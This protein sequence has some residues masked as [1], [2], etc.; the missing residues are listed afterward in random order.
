MSTSDTRTQRRVLHALAVESAKLGIAPDI[1]TVARAA[2]VDLALV[3]SVLL[4]AEASGLVHRNKLTAGRELTPEGVLWL[5]PEAFGGLP[6]IAGPVS[7]RPR[8]IVGRE[9]A[10]E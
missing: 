5:R 7:T 6:A 8:R 2:K 1:R 3:R 10:A 4:D 9:A